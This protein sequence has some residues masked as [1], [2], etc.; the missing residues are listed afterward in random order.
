MFGFRLSQEVVWPK[1]TT[2]PSFWPPLWPHSDPWEGLRRWGQTARWRVALSDF[3]HSNTTG[4]SHFKA[5]IKTSR[6]AKTAIKAGDG[7]KAQGREAGK[8]MRLFKCKRL[9]FWSSGIHGLKSTEQVWLYSPPASNVRCNWGLMPALLENS[10]KKGWV[11][12]DGCGL[13]T[14]Q[15]RDSLDTCK[16][17]HRTVSYFQVKNKQRVSWQQVM[18]FDIRH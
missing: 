9:P 16:S 8:G 18:F 15:L 11:P 12:R 13:I 2:E 4:A 6:G 10:Q 14:F 1:P 17:S 3:T 7:K 5:F